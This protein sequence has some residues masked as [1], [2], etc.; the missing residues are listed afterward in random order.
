MQCQTAKAF[1]IHGVAEGEEASWVRGN[2]IRETRRT[3]RRAVGEAEAVGAACAV[4]SFPTRRSA[5]LPLMRRQTP[6]VTREMQ[7]KAAHAHAS[8]CLPAPRA[9]SYDKGYFHA[10][11]P[12]LS[13][14]PPP[15]LPVSLFKPLSSSPP[16]VFHAGPAISLVMPSPFAFSL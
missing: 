11:R 13:P 10:R 5:P 12:S 6:L 15:F 1:Q 9:R 8:L 16:P 2:E 3:R 4:L 14:P 7:E